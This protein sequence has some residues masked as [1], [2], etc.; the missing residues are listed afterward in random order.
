[1]GLPLAGSGGHAKREQRKSKVAK[2]GHT[3]DHRAAQDVLGEPRGSTAEGLAAVE[4]LWS[5]KARR[6]GHARLLGDKG[7]GQRR[8]PWEEAYS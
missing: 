6:D 3:S 1:M 5:G 7:R 8:S 2:S 4:Q